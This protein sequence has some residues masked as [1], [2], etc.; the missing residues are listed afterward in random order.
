MEDSCLVSLKEVLNQ[1]NQCYMCLNN[2]TNP[3]TCPFSK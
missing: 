2:L 3:K 1:I